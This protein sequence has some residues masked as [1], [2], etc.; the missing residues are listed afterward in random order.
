MQ[1]C[2]SQNG[3]VMMIMIG[4]Q[5]NWKRGVIKLK[6]QTR[7]GREIDYTKIKKGKT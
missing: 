1:Y 6:Q 4:D 2:K 3:D 7:N 5:N